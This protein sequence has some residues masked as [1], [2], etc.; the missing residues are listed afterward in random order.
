[1]HAGAPH[2]DLLQRRTQRGF[3][4][5]E[6]LAAMVFMAILIPVVVEGLALSNRASVVAERK[7]VATQLAD[8]K[9]TELVVTRGW[10][11]GQQN[12]EFG[13]AWPGF[14]WALTRIAW[15]EDSMIELTVEVFFEVQG[16]PY[17]VRLA[18]LVEDDTAS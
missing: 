8:N 14:S 1:M 9:L 4:L 17:E 3:T 18:T 10:E 11:T 15:P 5:A 7:V 12:G 2:S 6:I 13:E 16:R